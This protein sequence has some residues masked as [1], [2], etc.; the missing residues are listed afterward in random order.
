MKKYYTKPEIGMIEV[1]RTDI[2]TTSGEP[3]APVELSVNVAGKRARNY[4]AQDVSML[5]E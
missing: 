2:I 1:D 5:D 3:T 4:G